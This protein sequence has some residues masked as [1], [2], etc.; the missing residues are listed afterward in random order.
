MFV[1]L[2][3]S[4]AFMLIYG[5]ETCVDGFLPARHTR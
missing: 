2:G 3:K 4:H 1:T 5:I